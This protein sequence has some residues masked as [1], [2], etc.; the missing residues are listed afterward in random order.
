MFVAVVFFLLGYFI[1]ASLMAGLGALMPGTREA[2]Q[3]TFFIILPLI[4][5]LWLNTAIALEPDGTLAV[6]LSLFPLTS[7][8]TMIMRMTATDVPFWQVLL[9]FVLLIAAAVVVI[10]LV[11]R[12]FRAQSLLS[13]TKPQLRRDRGGAAVEARQSRSKNARSRLV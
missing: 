12:V 5:P 4:V 8:V 9:A 2:A 6:V 7:P 11:S 1:Y 13:G 10:V 3:Y